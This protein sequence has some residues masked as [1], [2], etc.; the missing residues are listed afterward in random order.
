MS[1]P[2]VVD[3]A[4]SEWV[5]LA[6][7]TAKGAVYGITATVD[8]I[9]QNMA[10][11]A[12]IQRE[13]DAMKATSDR[14]SIELGMAS[15]ASLANDAVRALRFAFAEACDVN[16]LD[17]KEG[18]ADFNQ[19]MRDMAA[20]FCSIG[21][22]PHA[23]GIEMMMRQQLEDRLERDRH[24]IEAD[25]HIKRLQRAKHDFEADCSDAD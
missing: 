12:A 25:E 5:D 24:V 15:V 9:E 18:R 20:M 17:T 21:P 19:S 4:A 22:H 1:T 10:V 13:L 8:P 23:L 14:E 6:A 2:P 7:R 3:D 11:I 16:R